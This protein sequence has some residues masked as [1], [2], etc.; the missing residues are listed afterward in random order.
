MDYATKNKAPRV[1]FVGPAS[2][3]VTFGKRQLQVGDTIP[4]VDGSLVRKSVFEPVVDLDA[5]IIEEDEN[6]RS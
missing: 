1:L 2:A 5:E 6:G 3:K 4:D